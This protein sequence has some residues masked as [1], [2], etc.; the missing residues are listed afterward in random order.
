[1][2][3]FTTGTAALLLGL[4]VWL[5]HLHSLK[6]K[7]IHEAEHAAM[8]PSNCPIDSGVL[9]LYQSDRSSH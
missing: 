7:R 8:P 2:I 5:Y 6:E 9:D 4:L 1:L 3:R